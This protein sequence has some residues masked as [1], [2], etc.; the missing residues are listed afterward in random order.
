MYAFDRLL[1]RR[2]LAA[3]ALLCT[4]VSA[5]AEPACQGKD[6]LDEMRTREPAVHARLAA[7]AA[8]TINT[9]AVLW[10]IEKP[11]IPASFLLGTA[12]VSDPRI[13]SLSPRAR[14]AL[15]TA[16]QAVFEIADL[17]PESMAEAVTRNVP[18]FIYAD[19]RQLDQ[20]LLPDQF[21]KAAA[22]LAK[23]GMP[24]DVAIRIRP[25]LVFMMLAV[26]ECERLRQSAGQQAFDLQLTREAQTLGIPVIGLETIDSQLTALAAIPEDQQVAML[27]AAL[28]YADRAED[29][30]ETTVRLYLSRQMGLAMP[31]QR[32]LA[33]RIGIEPGSFAEFETEIVV[34]RNAGMAEAAAPLLAKGG[35]FIGVGALHLIGAS[36]L[37]AKFRQAGFAVTAVE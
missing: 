30:M 26:P 15:S 25:W 14:E 20:V 24:M 13:T 19:G 37:V 7:E 28:F 5:W 22:V 34:R 2:L 23:S 12:H 36:G 33:R 9:E 4:T 31:L 32:E 16:K 6:M 18:L 35:I 1:R 29:Q 10:R 11:G 21:E 3:G 8:A 27:Q 17:T